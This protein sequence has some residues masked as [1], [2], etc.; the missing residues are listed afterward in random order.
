VTIV[1]ICMGRLAQIQQ[2]L[3]INVATGCPI[4]FVDWSCPECSGDW[5][6]KAF[7]NVKVV[8]VGCKAH[9]EVCASRNRGFAEVKT[10]YVLFLDGD[11]FVRPAAISWM[12][13][14]I[15]N[16]GTW[17]ILYGGSLVV[18]T[19]LFRSIG[20]WDEVFSS[21]GWGGDDYECWARIRRVARRVQVPRELWRRIDHPNAER[22]AYFRGKD[23]NRTESM[24]R[25]YSDMLEACAK[26]GVILNFEQRL[27]LHA[28][29][30]RK[31]G[32]S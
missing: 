24:A 15:R 20:A 17:G 23:M 2:T 27:K 30:R 22:V 28:E 13:R 11:V 19:E 32:V 18:Q 16:Q 12:G 8:R 29:L 4:V 10:P 26:H 25:Q 1:T 31:C 7:P 14:Y 9:F 3:P 5:V 21:W 6:S